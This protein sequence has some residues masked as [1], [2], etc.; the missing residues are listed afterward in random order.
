MRYL[1]IVLLMLFGSVMPVASAIAQINVGI[2]LSLFPEL[3]RVPN[4][5]VY[6]APR[7]G[8]NFFFY[9]GY[10]WVYQG[11]NWYVSDWY[12]GP[13]DWVAPEEVPLF[14]LRIPVRYYR[15]PPVY[16]RHW[17]SDA[18]PRW[19]DHWGRDWE[20]HRSGWDRWNRNAAPKPAPLPVYQRKYSGDRYP[21]AEKQQELRS[22]NYR[23]QPREVVRHQ[24]AQERA[25]QGGPTSRER[26]D[27]P[28]ERDGRE[29]DRDSQRSAPPPTFERGAA[30]PR[31]QS[32]E[33]GRDDGQR[34]SPSQAA[35]R[36][37]APAVQQE[38]QAPASREENVQ[39]SKGA[40]PERGRAQEHEKERE[41]DD[42][43]RRDR[44]QERNR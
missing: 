34:S 36:Q 1:F 15:N 33:R 40:S 26:H 25:V 12:N 19:G 7:L 22:K 37:N 2:H 3:V 16:F 28:R 9:D 8:S 14:V 27:A 35:P 39:R 24:P 17:R 30:V 10:Y 18:P 4:Y 13:W 42:E 20:R 41:K 38:R 29:R 44:G 5:P 43:R 23:Y 21:H 32:P 6:Y 11:D 31:G